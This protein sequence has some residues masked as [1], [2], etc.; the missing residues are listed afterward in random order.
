MV[1][2]TFK[3]PSAVGSKGRKHWKTTK[4]R[5]L[6]TKEGNVVPQETQSVRMFYK[7]SFVLF[8]IQSEIDNI[9]PMGLPVRE[10]VVVSFPGL[11]PGL[12]N[13]A[14]SGLGCRSPIEN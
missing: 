10:G 5:V 8:F 6:R 9:A 14:P 4:P 2:R 3:S 7:F 13:V 11:H 1:L 12:V